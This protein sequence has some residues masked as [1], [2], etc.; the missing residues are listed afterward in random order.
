MIE[1]PAAALKSDILAKEVDFFS[2]GTNDLTQ[3]TL[4]GDRMNNAIAHVYDHGD[5]AI[6]RLVSLSTRN[7]HKNGIWIGICGEAASDQALIPS[8]LAIGVDELSV[9]P[10]YIPAVKQRVMSISIK[11]LETEE[12]EK[13]V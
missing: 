10:Y 6:L 12:F 5:L 3:Y 2:I 7:A 1:T 11:D 13:I 9:S 8:F 4:A